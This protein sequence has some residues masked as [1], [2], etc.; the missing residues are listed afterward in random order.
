MTIYLDTH[1]L[2]W[3]VRGER[4]KLGAAASRAIEDCELTVSPAV[5]LELELLHEI[6]R[7]RAS[8][9]TVVDTL[10]TDIGLR[11]CDL[12]FRTVVDYALKENWGGDPFDRLIVA[13]AK[14]AEAPL[15]TKD[16]RIRRHYSR[17]IW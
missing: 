6:G 7:L 17:V 1:I 9:L 5:V 11:V 8:A 14:A 4:D 3:L 12:P 13:N 15:V 16:A 2:V 10:A